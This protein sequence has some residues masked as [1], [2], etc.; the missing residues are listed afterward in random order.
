LPFD[1]GPV[2]ADAVALLTA[3]PNP[4][5]TM[6]PAYV[7]LFV[8]RVNAKFHH[9][10]VVDEE[11]SPQVIAAPKTPSACAWALLPT[12][13]ATLVNVLV[14]SSLLPMPKNDA[15][16]ALA[17]GIEAN[18][19]RPTVPAAIALPIATAFENRCAD[20]VMTSP[21]KYVIRFPAA[22]LLRRC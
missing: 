17:L 9:P 12:A 15:H 16:V 2:P 3:H 19:A 1:I 13:I 6:P 18:P 20:V 7:E 10:P 8:P 21:K 4:V 14:Q 22:R 11:S 5:D